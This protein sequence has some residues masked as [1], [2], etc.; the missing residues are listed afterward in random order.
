MPVSKAGDQKE[1]SHPVRADTKKRKRATQ[2]L[3]KTQEQDWWAGQ[4]VQVML[5]GKR[6]LDTVSSR[7][8]V[9][10]LK[11]SCTWSVKRNLVRTTIRSRPSFANGRA[12]AGRSIS[13]TKRSLSSTLGCAVRTVR[14]DSEPTSGSRI[15]G[16]SRRNSWQRCSGECLLANTK[17]R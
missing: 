12:S 2:I 5:H 10:Y 3:R 16:A 6:A 13:E 8:D 11:R 4:V 14:L 17:R 1:R 7:S 9:W 15:Q